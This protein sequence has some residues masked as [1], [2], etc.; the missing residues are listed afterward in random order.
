MTRRFIVLSLLAALSAGNNFG[1]VQQERK[2]EK[3]R[4]HVKAPFVKSIDVEWERDE[5]EP[6]TDVDVD[7]DD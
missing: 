6:R 4:V 3:N 7:V 2:P 5:D 1:C